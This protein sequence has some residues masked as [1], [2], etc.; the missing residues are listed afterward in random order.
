MKQDSC[1]AITLPNQR[2]MTLASAHSEIVHNHSY[3]TNTPRKFANPGPLGLSS[4][5]AT[6]FLLS[7]FNLQTRGIKTESLI[8]SMAF[9]Y[10][11]IIQV[12]AGM[13]EFAC[14]NTFGATAFSSYGGFWIS[15]GLILS[16]NSGILAAYATKKDE[17]ESA[18]GL[19]LLAWFIFTS[20][21]LL[22]SLRTSVA[23]IALFFFLD[24]TFLLLAIGKLCTEGHAL[25]KAGGVFG[26]I[27]AFIAWYVAAA[28]LLEAEKS[29]IRLPT[30]PLGESSDRKD[31]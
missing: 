13:W 20:V 9:G 10:G 7:L 18:L 8:V 28:G 25:A 24:V 26:L 2:P 27:T 17:L 4:F 23:L 12:L 29:F 6:T 14:G 5:A 1:D 22:G 30:I 11:G 15:F 21:M 19:Y 31:D 16:P 3:V